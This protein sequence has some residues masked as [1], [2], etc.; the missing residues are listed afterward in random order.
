MTENTT[1]PPKTDVQLAH[2][3][4][5]DVELTRILL[6]SATVNSDVSDSTRLTGLKTSQ[7]F[8]SH[9]DPPQ[10]GEFCV[11]TTFLI[12]L[13]EEGETPKDV[14]N[15]TAEYA[16]K[17]KLPSDKTYDSLAVKYFAE[18]NTTVHLWPYWRELVHTVVAR[19]GLGSLTLP[20]YRVKAK[21]VE[22]PANTD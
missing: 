21:A 3:V 15:L 11:Y 22:Q 1:R 20:V 12:S 8:K 2:E 4:S 6:K 5:R 10:E 16:V 19:V 17:Y 18:L 14:L 13:V 9:Y 7:Q